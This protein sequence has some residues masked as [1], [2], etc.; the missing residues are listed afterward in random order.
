MIVAEVTT[1][2]L[3]DTF[4]AEA[5][6]SGLA[7]RRAAALGTEEDYAYLENVIKESITLDPTRDKHALSDLSWKF[8]HRTNRMANSPRLSASLRA[9]S[10]PLMS[11]F[12]SDVPHWWDPNQDEHTQIVAALRERDADAAEALTVAH[13]EHIGEALVSFLRPAPH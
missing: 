3:I 1:Q 5:F 10:I 8:H 7:A 13:F 11:D 12:V 2:D 6:L 9:V 4:R